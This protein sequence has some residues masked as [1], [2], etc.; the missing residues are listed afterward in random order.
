MQFNSLPPSCEGN[1]AITAIGEIVDGDTDRLRA[2]VQKLSATLPPAGELNAVFL[3]SPGGKLAE[4]ERLAGAIQKL[5]VAI[6]LPPGSQC[7]SACFL[8]FAADARRSVAADALVGV[9]SASLEGH[10]TTA[11]MAIT[12]QMARDA[13][14]MG[15]PPQIVGKMVTTTPGRMAWLTRDDLA[16]MDVRIVDPDKTAAPKPQAVPTAPSGAPSP[17]PIA[18]PAAQPLEQLAQRFAFDYFG[19]WSAGNTTSMT[20]VANVYADLVDFY[21]APTSRQ[22]II[23]LKRK[24]V[25]RWPQRIYTVRPSSLSIDCDQQTSTC[26]VAGLVDWDCRDATRGAHSSGVA[27][28]TVKVTFNRSGAAQV[29]GK[30]RSVVSRSAALGYDV[31]EYQVSLSKASFMRSLADFACVANPITQSS[32]S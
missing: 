11:S 13:A 10:E 3:D 2:L 31:A 26:V 4:G 15:V 32:K 25:E 16:P 14:D 6:V 17:P 27:N 19:K 21:G 9:H 28:F 12:T 24:F 5:H 22:T 20:Y 18:V 8:L 30:T 1:V 7:D 23:D 29:I